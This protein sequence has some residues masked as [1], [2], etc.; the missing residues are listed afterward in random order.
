[1]RVEI[2]VELGSKK[3]IECVKLRKQHVKEN[4]GGKKRDPSKDLKEDAM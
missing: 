1:M 4:S 2:L 3:F